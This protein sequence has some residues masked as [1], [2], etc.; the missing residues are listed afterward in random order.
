MITALGSEIN[1]ALQIV[2]RN[3]FLSQKISEMEKH[4]NISIKEDLT[5]PTSTTDE[6]TPPIF[7]ITINSKGDEAQSIREWGISGTTEENSVAHELGHV[8]FNYLTNIKK[9][10]PNSNK[11]VGLS[12]DQWYV[13]ESEATARE[14]DNYT[15]PVWMRRVPLITGR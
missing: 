13:I 15:R 3:H 4:Y 8:Y 7:K 10:P 12:K 2:R 11:P 5:S 9:V 14:W 6:T 1:N